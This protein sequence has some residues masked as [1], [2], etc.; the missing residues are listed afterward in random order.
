MNYWS[1]FKGGTITCLFIHTQIKFAHNMQISNLHVAQFAHFFLALIS[2]ITVYTI[3]LL[4]IYLCMLGVISGWGGSVL[5]PRGKSK[6]ECTSLK[7]IRVHL[8]PGSSCGLVAYTL[9][10]L[11]QRYTL[12]DIQLIAYL[13]TGRDAGLMT[14]ITRLGSLR[15][16]HWS[17]RF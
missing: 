6:P 4:P 1:S 14:H 11:A 16:I 9:H 10:I 7:S 12:W 2:C 15:G 3:G 17:K 13:L 8:S 5:P